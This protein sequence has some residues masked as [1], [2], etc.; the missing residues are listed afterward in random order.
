MKVDCMVLG[1]LPTGNNSPPDENKAQ[2]LPSRT[3]ISRT[4]PHQDHYQPVKPFIRTN[5]CSVRNCPGRELSGYRD[6]LG[7]C[8]YHIQHNALNTFTIITILI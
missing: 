5:T 4:T 6:L 1:Q 7:L 2:L 8:Q 3:T